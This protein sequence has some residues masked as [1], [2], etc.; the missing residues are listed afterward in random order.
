MNFIVINSTKKSNS[1]VTDVFL[2]THTFKLYIH[3]LKLDRLAKCCM[4]TWK[5]RAGRIDFVTELSLK[6]ILLHII[7]LGMWINSIIFEFFIL[8]PFRN[9][10]KILFLLLTQLSLLQKALLSAVT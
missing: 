1:F 7:E 2:A 5:N 4:K 9:G 6:F 8:I 3:R 10:I